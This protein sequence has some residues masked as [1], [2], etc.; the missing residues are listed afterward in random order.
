MI[1]NIHRYSFTQI[2]TYLSCPR[3]YQ[4]KYIIKPESITVG[5]PAMFIGSSVHNII[6]DI[7]TRKM[8]GN[9][10]DNQV[11]RKVLKDHRV[12]FRAKI[13]ELSKLVN[14]PFD[15]NELTRQHDALVDQW[16]NDVLPEFDPTG[17]ESE[18]TAE[19]GGHRFLMYIDA[20]HANKKIVDWKVT[21]SK[22]SKSIADN[23][24]QLSIYSMGTGLRSVGFCSLVRPRDGKERNWK[25]SIEFVWS[26]RNETELK[27]AEKV[28]TGVIDG[29][30]N[31]IFPPCDP[32]NFLCNNKYC[33]FWLLCRGQSDTKEPTW[34]SDII[35]EW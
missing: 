24:L 3:K 17:V 19:I 15:V 26:T 10:H 34:L 30:N 7:L 33:D 4:F 28:I 25:P 11:I 22:K 13:I 8:N 35:G 29:I 14:I 1:A 16:C 31:D 23:S 20:I 9:Q 18:I 2:D 21:T 5:S 12:D 27:W 6:A 32:S